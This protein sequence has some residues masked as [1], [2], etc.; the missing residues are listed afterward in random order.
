MRKIATVLTLFVRWSFAREP[1]RAR[2]R[3]RKRPV[4]Y[5]K[6]VPCFLL[7]NPARSCRV[8]G[9]DPL[10]VGYARVSTRDQSPALQLN[11]L[12]EAG[13]D[14]VFTEKASGAQRDCR[15]CGRRSIISVLATRW[16]C[17]SSIGSRGQCGSLSRRPKI[18]RSARS[19]FACSPRRSTPP[20]Q[21]GGSSFTS[22]RQSPSSS[23]S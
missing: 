7:R 5:L 20:A 8:F 22:S 2:P 15:S 1:R 23:A 11:A 21:E 19:A 6:T 3:P 18:S 4:Q 16:R 13:C 10:L 14:K 9:E 17:G 12:R